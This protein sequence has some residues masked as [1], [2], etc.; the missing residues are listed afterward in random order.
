LLSE[1]QNRHRKPSQERRDFQ[2]L[3]GCAKPGNA[4]AKGIIETKRFAA[5]NC[6]HEA[7]PSRLKQLSL[8]KNPL[9]KH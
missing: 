9:S 8:E 4:K 3:E 6:Q 5:I 1:N 2:G 7:T